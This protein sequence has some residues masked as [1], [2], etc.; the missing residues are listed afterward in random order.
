MSKVGPSLGWDH[1][2]FFTHS[3]YLY[4]SFGDSS[5]EGTQQNQLILEQKERLEEFYTVF[6]IET[7]TTWNSDFIHMQSLQNMTE[8]TDEETVT[9]AQENIAG[10]H[11]KC[12]AWAWG[13]SQEHFYSTVDWV[14]RCY[15]IT[16]KLEE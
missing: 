4:W 14:H 10:F 15:R 16:F 11:W 7:H 1:L 6:F 13:Q 9:T 3:C 5:F 12:M 8:R 2:T